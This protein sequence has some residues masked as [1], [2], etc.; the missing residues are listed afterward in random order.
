MKVQLAPKEALAL[1]KA[2]I[3][4]V[5]KYLG[6][7]TFTEDNNAKL[8]I[9]K[10]I[11]RELDVLELSIDDLEYASLHTRNIFELYLILTHINSNQK[12]LEC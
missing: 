6:E 12:A 11:V 10:N 9:L 8:M 4:K 2:N 5:I 3:S 7:Q 1:S